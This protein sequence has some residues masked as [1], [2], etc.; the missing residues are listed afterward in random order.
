MSARWAVC[1]R[2]GAAI[3]IWP[4]QPFARPGN[5][6]LQPGGYPYAPLKGRPVNLGPACPEREQG[7][8]CRAREI[9]FGHP[10]ILRIWPGMMSASSTGK[11]G[12]GAHALLDYQLAQAGI[13][14]T[15]IAGC[16]GRGIHP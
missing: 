5:G 7:V 11:R 14:P 15:S 1:L 2:S 10:V 3:A 6:H 12:G 8:D 9:P 4:R 13:S 16:K